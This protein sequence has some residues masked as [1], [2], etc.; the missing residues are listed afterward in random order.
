[1]NLSINSIT[2]IFKSCDS[3][4]SPREELYTGKRISS[5]TK[6]WDLWTLK[7]LGSEEK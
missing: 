1:M 5:K 7:G 2:V 4:K 3:V 6:T